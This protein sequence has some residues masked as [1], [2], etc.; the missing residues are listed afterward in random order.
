[1]SAKVTSSVITVVKFYS[2]ADEI[3]LIL[4]IQT[5]KLPNVK[6]GGQKKI[7]ALGLICTT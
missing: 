4:F 2:E 6:V 1:M 3:Q 5:A 7:L